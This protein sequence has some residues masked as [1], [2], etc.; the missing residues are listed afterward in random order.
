ML[1]AELVLRWVDAMKTFLSIIGFVVLASGV[2]WS[3]GDKY[4][5]RCTAP[6][7]DFATTS[8][9]PSTI[10]V[11]APSGI[12]STDWLLGFHI[13]Q[14][15]AHAGHRVHLVRSRTEL[16]E[17]LK[18][19]RVDLVMADFSLMN[20]LP[21]GPARLPIVDQ[22]DGDE[23]PQLRKEYAYILKTPG[24]K[25]TILGTIEYEVRD[26]NKKTS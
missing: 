17:V 20:G 23:L 15:L 21:V 11:F 9:A 6:S 19:E 10:V 3:C 5:V 4:L 1:I 25:S 24:Q 16:D 22:T 12:R 14:E 2:A 7:R 26:L 18:S 8:K 13:D